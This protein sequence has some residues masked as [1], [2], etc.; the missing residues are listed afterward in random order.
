LGILR[1]IL[2]LKGLCTMRFTF[3]SQ[4]F[5]AVVPAVP[6]HA[7]R[8]DGLEALQAASAHMSPSSASYA[9]AAIDNW[10]AAKTAEGR[11]PASF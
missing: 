3:L 10:P 11:L 7:E 6:A 8:D 4:L 9:Q 2:P 1:S 5:S